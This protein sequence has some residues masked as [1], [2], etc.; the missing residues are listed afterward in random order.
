M[1]A[2]AKKSVNGLGRQGE[3][4]EREEEVEVVDVGWEEKEEERGS[5]MK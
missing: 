4:E 1:A 2:M 3:E 5:G